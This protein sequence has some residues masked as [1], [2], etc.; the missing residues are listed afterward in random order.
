MID[1]IPG[2]GSL[3]VGKSKFFG[4]LFLIAISAMNVIPDV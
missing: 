2:R 4:R 3:M 1:R